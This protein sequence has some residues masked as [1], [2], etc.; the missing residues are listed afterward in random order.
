MAAVQSDLVD[1]V[2][3]EVHLIQSLK[4]IESAWS[5]INVALI[6]YELSEEARKAMETYEKGYLAFKENVVGNLLNVYQSGNPDEVEDIYDEWLDYKP[7]VMKTID[8]VAEILKKTVK[9]RYEKSQNM[10]LKMNRLIAFIATIGIGLFAALAL[11]TVRSIK[12]P[13][14]IIVE[15]AEHVASGDLTRTI[16]ITSEDE[17]GCMAGRLNK[18]IENLRESFQK[19]VVSIGQMTSDTEGLSGLSRK[20]LQGAESQRAK[21]E[22]VAESS[23]EMS[24]TILDVANNTHEA[25]DVT[26]ESL[27]AA[28]SGKETVSEAVDTISK[29]AGSVS[30]ASS[31][32]DGLGNNLEEI[33]E[34]VSVIQDISD[35]T[36]LLALNAAIEAARSGEHGRGFAVV[37]DEVRKLAERTA[38]AT[39]E[40]ASKITVIQKGSKASMSIME[41]G[42]AL[43]DESVA[44]AEK[45]GD[46]LQKI[47]DSSDRVTAIVQRVAAATAEQS[48]SA[49]E[50]SYAM[51][52]IAGIINDHCGLAEEVE[53]SASNLSSLAQKV[54]DQVDYFKT[55]HNSGVVATTKESFSK[56][57]VSA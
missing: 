55:E 16:N 51:E 21:G 3:G 17:M 36:N 38:R 8:Q 31:T 4:D 13:I 2:T 32:I 18:M 35:Q 30:E 20:L 12:K 34:I 23:S 22:Q 57:D 24:Q 42:S 41:K 27:E 43:A 47:V 37:A 56:T 44:K 50:V 1:P 6:D 49:E 15:E 26:K 53:K 10:A 5:R 11:V 46:A 52:H 28:R 33:Y 9:E 45:A 54:I 40:I 29:L 25:S 39:D 19:I 48:S 14:N 7:L